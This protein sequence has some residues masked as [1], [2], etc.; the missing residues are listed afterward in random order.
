MLDT[1]LVALIALVGMM[2]MVFI[3]KVTFN[4]GVTI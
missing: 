2:V 3:Y 1:A 4:K